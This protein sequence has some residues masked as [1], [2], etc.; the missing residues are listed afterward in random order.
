MILSKPQE[1]TLNE[2]YNAPDYDCIKHQWCDTFK[3][4]D[5]LINGN[6]NTLTL[7]ALE[8]KGFITIV[9]IGDFW[10]DLVKIIH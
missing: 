6:W 7:Q 3:R 1:K 10:N 8:R 4:E 5:G 2:I 9:H